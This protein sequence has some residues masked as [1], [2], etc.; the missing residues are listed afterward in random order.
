MPASEV[1][2]VGMQATVQRMRERL[3]S[4]AAFISF[5]V[6]F[7][8]PAY[9]P[10]TGTPEVGGFTTYE[11][12]QLIRGL[13]GLRLVAYDVVE[14]L[15]AYDYGDITALAAANMAYEFAALTAMQQKERAAQGSA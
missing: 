1:R 15:P 10:G 8:D 14:V 7:L 2:E 6:D 11:A 12:Q 4:G 13:A 3:G 9:A 5:D